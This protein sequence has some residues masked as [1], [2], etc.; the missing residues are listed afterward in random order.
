MA[1]VDVIQYLCLPCTAGLM[2]W[3]THLLQLGYCYKQYSGDSGSVP[4]P[5][6]H[7]I[8][9]FPSQCDMQELYGLL[10]S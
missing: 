4:S 7:P 2:S 9:I 5:P 3:M 10:T 8:Q 1:T 6:T